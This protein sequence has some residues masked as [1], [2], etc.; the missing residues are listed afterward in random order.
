MAEIK[1]CPNCGARMDG[2]TDTNVG[3][4]LTNLERIKSM[5]VDELSDFLENASSG[6]AVKFFGDYISRCKEYIKIW[7]E[8]E[9]SE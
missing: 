7:L 9:V 6:L 5:S 2:A 3:G 4:K 1:P 8:S